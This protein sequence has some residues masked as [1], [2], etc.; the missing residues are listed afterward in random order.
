MTHPPSGSGRQVQAR[1]TAHNGL[2][3]AILFHPKSQPGW[4]LN[5]VCGRVVTGWHPLSLLF[6]CTGEKR[7]FG[8]T[9]KCIT[10]EH[11]RKM[12][13]YTLPCVLFW[14]STK[15]INAGKEGIC[16]CAVAPLPCSFSPL[17]HCIIVYVSS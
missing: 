9:G 16:G 1:M 13:L 17:L 6:Y 3:F 15:L 4:C 10:A 12:K 5:D 8:F 7:H 14:L 2:Q 11:C